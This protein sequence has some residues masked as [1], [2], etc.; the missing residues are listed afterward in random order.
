VA[1][2]NARMSLGIGT[3]ARCG[4]ILREKGFMLQESA[5]A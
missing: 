5:D 2:Q 1:G 4:L 3:F